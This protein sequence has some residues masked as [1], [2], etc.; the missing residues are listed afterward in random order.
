MAA[1]DS[2]LMRLK[3]HMDQGMRLYVARFPLEILLGDFGQHASHWCWGCLIL[4]VLLMAMVGDVDGFAFGWF[5][6]IFLAFA[7][8]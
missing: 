7:C 6:A 3:N 1:G 4:L 8:G 5:W 2:V